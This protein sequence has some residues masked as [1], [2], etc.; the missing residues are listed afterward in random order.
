MD[1]TFTFASGV[2]SRSLP[3]RQDLIREKKTSA[4]QKNVRR[5]TVR[6]NLQS[7]Q[8]ELNSPHRQHISLV[9]TMV[10]ALMFPEGK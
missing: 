9:T 1:G 3:S 10:A 4:G 2:L 7:H 6:L 8:L 5:Y